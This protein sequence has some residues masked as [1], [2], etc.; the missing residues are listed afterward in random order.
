MPQHPICGSRLAMYDA[1]G[2]LRDNAG[3]MQ[4][5]ITVR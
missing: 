3:D 1:F 5:T 2:A 4:A